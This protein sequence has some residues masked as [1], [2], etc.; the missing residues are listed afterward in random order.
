M[1][2]LASMDWKQVQRDTVAEAQ[3]KMD[4][5]VELVQKCLPVPPNIKAEVEEGLRIPYD[6]EHRI[7]EGDFDA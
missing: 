7:L 6:L 4:T 3:A 2:T 5:Y 1:T